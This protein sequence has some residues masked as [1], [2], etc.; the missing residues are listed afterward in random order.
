MSNLQNFRPGDTV[1]WHDTWY[2]DNKRQEPVVLSGRV[3]TITDEQIVAQRENK[4]YTVNRALCYRTKGSAIEAYHKN[5]KEVARRYQSMDHYFKV[6]ENIWCLEN[7][8]CE[9]GVICGIGDTRA[10]IAVEGSRDRIIG[11]PL[12]LCYRKL[13]DCMHAAE[14]R[15]V[16]RAEDYGQMVTDADSLVRFLMTA[17]L[18][19]SNPDDAV[20]IAANTAYERLASQ[21]QAKAAE[22]F[23]D[24][25]DTIPV[26]KDTPQ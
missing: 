15:S 16:C 8:K 12:N 21:S 13:N 3:F 2:N 11:V 22:E 26:N 24:A 9:K 6:G 20:I 25:L 18:N 17:Y 7:E 14:I 5:A 19:T 23:A 4:I 1:W 10:I